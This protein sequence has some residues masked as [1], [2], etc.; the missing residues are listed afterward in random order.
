MK[1]SHINTVL[2]QHPHTRRQYLGTF[3]SDQCPTKPTPL[4]C[5][6]SNTDPRSM[7]GQ[8]WI[9]FYVK[10]DGHVY[11]F[12]PYGLPPISVYH[13]KFLQQSPDHRGTYNR[14]QLQ[15]FYTQTCGAHCINFLIETCRTQ[16]PH[17]T[18][19]NLLHLPTNFTDRIVEPL[20]SRH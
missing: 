9:A 1:T 13:Q 18:L 11:Y 4:T 20:L 15:N 19:K 14:Q 12:D 3:S 17:H 6:V 2:T 5:F 8:H 16:D 7:P 10:S